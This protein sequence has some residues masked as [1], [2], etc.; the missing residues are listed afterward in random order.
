MLSGDFK[1]A[2]NL[3]QKVNNSDNLSLKAKSLF[4]I[5]NLHWQQG[6]IKLAKSYCV[7]AWFL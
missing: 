1:N 4:G 5:G 7:D 2:F 6:N 3:F